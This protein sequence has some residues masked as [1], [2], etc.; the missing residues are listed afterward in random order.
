MMNYNELSKA[1]REELLDML[2][3]EMSEEQKV[4]YCQFV[5]DRYKVSDYFEEHLMLQRLEFMLRCH[6]EI[7]KE[8]LSPEEKATLRV[9]FNLLDTCTD[10]LYRLFYEMY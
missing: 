3:D 1:E 4:Q 10:T 7:N 5:Q 2:P 8:N 9:L 6:A